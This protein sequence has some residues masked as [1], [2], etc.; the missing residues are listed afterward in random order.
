MEGVPYAGGEPW[1]HVDRVDALTTVRT[2]VVY[3]DPAGSSVIWESWTHQTRRIGR[4]P[5]TPRSTAEFAWEDW[6]AL[7]RI[8][9]N[10][11]LDVVAWVEAVAGQPR[12]L[13]V[14]QPSS[15]RV[16]ARTLL[17]PSEIS[18]VSL[19]GVDAEFVFYRTG[20]SNEVWVWPWASGV[21]PRAVRPPG[22]T[23]HDVSGGVWAFGDGQWLRF[24]S[25]EGGPMASVPAWY[26][27]GTA[28]G[29]AL[30][31][32]GS[33]WYAPAAGEFVHTA[34]G[35]RIPLRSADV[36]DCCSAGSG[37]TGPAEY[38]FV[39]D[40]VVVCDARTGLCREPIPLAESTS[41]ALPAN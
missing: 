3:V 37:W 39:D 14:V 4:G 33:F 16:L 15:G 34:T 9:G 21:A 22:V 38:T 41:A 24:E 40:S 11:A 27:D 5:W 18:S 32:D 12:E 29:A 7:R 20:P 6:E 25:S 26:Y 8:V 13:L 31:P 35:A 10:P 1:P 19:A 36:S 23:I 2:G 28:F 30:S 17:G